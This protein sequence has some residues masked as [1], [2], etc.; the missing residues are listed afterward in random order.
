MTESL[1]AVACDTW[2]PAADR[3]RFPPPGRSGLDLMAKGADLVDARH[4]L[5]FSTR[6]IRK[7]TAAPTDLTAA[8]NPIDDRKYSEIH[9]IR[10]RT[11]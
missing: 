8:I 6:D 2:R 7:A 3:Y 10:D 9:S 5:D 4:D 1:T 11:A